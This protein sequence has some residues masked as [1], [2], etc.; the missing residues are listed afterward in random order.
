MTDAENSEN[1]TRTGGRRGPRPV[2]LGALALA[3]AGAVVAG[4]FGLSW[5]LAGGDE[6]LKRAQTRDEVAR[7]ADSAIVTFN[8][9]DY[10]KI[11]EGL[12]NWLNA[13]TGPLHDDVVG[14]R[15]SSKQTI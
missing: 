1:D 15:A 12:D 2:L 14:R 5:I 3:V 9:L 13:S 4:W 7:V 8:T 10:Q 6:S 11:D